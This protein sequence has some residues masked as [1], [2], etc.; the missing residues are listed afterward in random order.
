M[1]RILVIDDAEHIRIVLS[2][3]LKL[4][5]HTVDTA[6]NGDEGLRLFDLNHYDLLI[7]DVVMPEKDG[8]EVLMALKKNASSVRI[9]A[10]SGGAAMLDRQHLL[11]TA[12]ILGAD[13]ILPKPL[14]FLKL[15]MVVKE[16]LEGVH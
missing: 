8:F 15:Q 2:E 10:M 13:R 11:K 7:T 3:H 4:E 5:G 1:A 16:V 12:K 9:I 14:D 6:E